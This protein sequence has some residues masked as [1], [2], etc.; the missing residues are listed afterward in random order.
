MKR[1][2][3]SSETYT[4]PDPSRRLVFQEGTIEKAHEETIEGF[5]GTIGAVILP[6]KRELESAIHLP[7]REKPQFGGAIEAGMMKGLSLDEALKRLN[8][9]IMEAEDPASYSGPKE[10]G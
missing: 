2:L 4:S 10:R 9:A 5:R 1:K 8:R 6:L 3:E 7:E